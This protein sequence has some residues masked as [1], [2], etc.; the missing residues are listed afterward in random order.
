MLK[1]STIAAAAVFCVATPAAALDYVSVFLP[2]YSEAVYG[3]PEAPK[4][5]E[6]AT[7]VDAKQVYILGHHLGDAMAS[8]TIRNAPV[9][10]RVL[11]VGAVGFVGADGTYFQ[12]FAPANNTIWD[13]VSFAI[14]VEVKDSG[15]FYQR[16]YFDLDLKIGGG[17]PVAVPEPATWALMILGFASVGAAVRRRRVAVAG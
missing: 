4:F 13:D 5:F 14:R 7:I 16:E 2:N 10:A 17:V 9:G 11:G 1:F 15:G 8:Y 6:P 3:T 12:D